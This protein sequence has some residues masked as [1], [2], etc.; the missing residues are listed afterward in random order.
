MGSANC[1]D[2][3]PDGM[4]IFTDGLDNTVRIWDM[5]KNDFSSQIFS[6]SY[7]H[8]GDWLAVGMESS[9]IEV[10]NTTNTYKYQLNL[11]KS[12]VMSLKFAHAVKWLISTGKDNYLNTWRTSY[13][14][15]ISQVS[16]Y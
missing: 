4:S 8:D 5:R 6:L 1:I 7:C 13:G 15:S 10:V 14:A 16:S 3:S 9:H 2:I 12:C 11:H